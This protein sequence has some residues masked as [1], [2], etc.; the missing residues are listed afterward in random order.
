M[1]TSKPSRPLTEEEEKF[2]KEALDASFIVEY[3]ESG[4]PI[5][6]GADHNSRCFSGD[7]DEKADGEGGASYWLKD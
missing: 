3:H 4:Y 1:T 6:T 5:A 2:V 7:V